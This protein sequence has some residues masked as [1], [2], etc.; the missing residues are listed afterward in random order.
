MDSTSLLSA[1][2][3]QGEML[4]A[5]PIV[6]LSEPVP[7]VPGWT[8]EHVVRHTGK[9]HQWV[10]AALQATADT[11]LSEIVRVGDMPRGPECVAAYR[12]AFDSLLDTFER[13]DPEHPAPTMVGPGTAAWWLRRQ[14]H[15]VSVHRIDV[16][17]TLRAAGG[18]SV[19]E[20]DPEIA[21]DGVDEWVHIFLAMLARGDRLPESLDGRTIHLHGT[22]TEAAEWHLA[23]E[24]GAVTVTREHRK[25][26]V[27]LRGPA[28]DLLLT[29]WRRRPLA[30]LDVIGD[31]TV[32][33]DLL[34]AAAV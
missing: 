1:L 14:T 8:V 33:G 31:E 10:I 30:R 12:L 22:D 18:P 5:T 6:A 20:L 3:E 28:Q 11:P 29:L 27:A 32:A 34:A 25:G 26:D 4:A 24:S 19:P 9:V 17:D 2:R 16:S 7:M 15:E 23:F 13:L 21:A